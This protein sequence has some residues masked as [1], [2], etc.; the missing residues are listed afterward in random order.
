MQTIQIS[1]DAVSLADTVQTTIWYS[2]ELPYNT[3]RYKQWHLEGV[4]KGQL[5][6]KTGPRSA[7]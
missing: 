4:Q 3:N 2:V 7:N 6:P 5:Y 1:A